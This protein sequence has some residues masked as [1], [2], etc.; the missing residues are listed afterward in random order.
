MST[1]ETEIYEFLKRFHNRYVP[2]TDISRSVG[3]RKNFNA[4]R[5]WAQPVLRRM[6][7]EG[8]V[9][10]NPFGEYRVKFS[11]EDST[12]FKKALETPGM[13]L[14]DTTIVSLSDVKCDRDEAV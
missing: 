4:D 7:I 6:E 13:P 10:A 14:G 11:S 5:L 1:E 2:V 3:A 8:W 12:T 9:E